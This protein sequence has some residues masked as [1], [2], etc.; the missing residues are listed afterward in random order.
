MTPRADEDVDGR[1][2]RKDRNRLAVL[3][4]L[5]ALHREGVYDPSTADVAVRAGISE[6]SLYRYFDDV[7]DLSRAVFEYQL[8]LA[9]PLLSIDVPDDATT[10]AKI[11]ALVAT[12]IRLYE[13]IGPAGRA[14]RVV[15]PRNDVIAARLGEARAFLRAQIG[16][17]LAEELGALP[18]GRRTASHAAIDVLCS[19]EAHEL[20]CRGR[21]MPRSRV[22]A[23]L[24]QAITDLLHP[25][26]GCWP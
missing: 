7:A 15:A 18:P 26:R 3:D 22:A 23:M 8:E 13:T 6:R 12:R 10:T 24:V 1:R 19:F 11:N 25:D 14:A 2:A 16:R 4:A 20:L 17:L 5:A 21:G 9:R